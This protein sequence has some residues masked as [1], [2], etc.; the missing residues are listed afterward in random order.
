[1]LLWSWSVVQEGIKVRLNG[2]LRN[3]IFLWN[4]QWTL[5]VVT[6][7][8]EFCSN[9][10]RKLCLQILSYYIYCIMWYWSEIGKT[11]QNVYTRTHSIIIIIIIIAY[12]NVSCLNSVTVS[13]PYIDYPKHTYTNYI[14]VIILY[15]S[16]TS[17]IFLISEIIKIIFLT[18][19]LFNNFHIIHDLNQRNVLFI[20]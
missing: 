4:E 8:Y 9:I 19:I 17:I 11:M 12:G 15:I 7:T 14:I 1:M 20:N 18:I 5:D 13:S 2:F 6:S 16:F 3:V 10:K